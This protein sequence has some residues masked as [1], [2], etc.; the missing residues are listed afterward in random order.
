MLRA[1]KS[2]RWLLLVC[3][4]VLIAC[5]GSDGQIAQAQGGAAGAA[6]G[7][8]AGEGG[9]ASFGGSAGQIGVGGDA[10]QAGA[11]G[12]AGAGGVAGAGGGGV[13]GS[14]GAGGSTPTPPPDVKVMTFNIRTGTAN[15]GADS[16]N[17]RKKLVFD[18]FKKRDADFVGVQEAR[19]FQ[20]KEI[21]AAVSGYKRIGVS[22]EGG[23]V[24]EYCAIYY[25]TARFELKKSETFW[26]SNTP[27]QPGS[28]SWGNT[29]ARIVTWG[30]FMDKKANYRF[31]IYN[32]HFDHQSQNSREK[33]AVLLSKKIN[34][35]VGSRPYVVTGDFNAGESNVVTRYLK[36]NAKI[37]GFANPVP[38]RDSFRV[39]NPD[40]TNVG[41]AHG[42]KG[43]TGGNKIDYVFISKGQKV[44]NAFIDHYHVGSSYPSDHFPVIGRMI[45]PAL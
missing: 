43:G 30:R 15:D 29:L 35:E 44:V 41:T 23:T 27:N 22:R 6:L 25:R 38:M 8:N 16:W 42:F 5:G 12:I 10:G 34:N 33:S 14:A 32:T 45:L 40:A 18:V 19:L 3:V 9:S 26:L 17:N 21:D 37:D 31:Y 11:A 39:D 36:G 7:G 28:K 20:L 2:K 4:L 24:G 1:L 13:G